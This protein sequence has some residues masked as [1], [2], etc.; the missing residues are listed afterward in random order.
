MKLKSSIKE[1]KL[2]GDRIIWLIVMGLSLISI[3]AVY[4]SSSAL[5]YR[6]D[7]TNSYYLMKQ[8]L[9]V[10]G[11]MGALFLCY[12]IPIK[13]YRRISLGLFAASCLLLIYVAV[14][15]EEING[16]R[17]WIDLGFM[18]F[19]PSEV[20]KISVVLYLA[21]VLE[22]FKFDKF[23]D[24]LIKIILPVGLLCILCLLG[25]VSVTI[26]VAAISFIILVC[27]G[28]KPRFLLY[29]VGMAIAAAGLLYVFHLATGKITRIDTLEARIER[30]FS[31]NDDNMTE[32]ELQE[33][34]DKT[35][36]IQEAREAIELGGFF[37]RGLG[38]SIKKNSLPHPYSDFIFTIIV[39]ETGWLGG[40]VVVILY[41]W[42]LFRCVVI[43]H[44][45]KKVFPM[46]VVMGLASLIILQAFIHI[47]VNLGIGLVTGQTLPLISLGGTSF[48]ILGGAV[49]IILSVNRTIEIRNDELKLQNS[50]KSE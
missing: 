8:S 29:T 45:C 5:A 12:F 40:A 20:A 34:K 23:M 31:G 1:A 24:Y 17:R 35:Y 30:K 47:I 27:A 28:I 9:F 18:S 13:W 32:A 39:E 19:Q 11:G 42:F 15:G 41:I 36:Q 7:T 6:Y 50:V 16:A 21:T 10:A 26:I 3:L 14:F 48:I 38:N 44:S 25:S 43:A 33:Y 37:G 49:G 46:I 22:V 4:S 2:R